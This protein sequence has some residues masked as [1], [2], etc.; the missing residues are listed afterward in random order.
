MSRDV[1]ANVMAAGNPCK[2]LRPMTAHEL[3]GCT[4][5]GKGVMNVRAT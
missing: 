5:G 2:V 4:Q 3:E 1:P